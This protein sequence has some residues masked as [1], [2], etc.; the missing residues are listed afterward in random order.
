VTH[1]AKR[2][3]RRPAARILLVEDDEDTRELM[4][5]A[6]RGEGFAVEEATDAAEALKR[7]AASAFDLVITDYDM[8]VQTGAAMLHEAA[9]R[10]LLGSAAALVITA[11]PEHEGVDTME[12][13]RKPIDLGHFLAEIAARLPQAADAATEMAPRLEAVL[14]VSSGSA[15][16]A[17]A[18][19]YLEEL[20]ARMGVPGLR[21][22]VCDVSRDARRAEQDRVVYTPTL[23]RRS[24]GPPVW[25]VGDPSASSVVPDLLSIVDA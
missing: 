18:R 19:R 25:V 12:V 24:P 17:R 14:Y 1:R 9:R 8:P 10:G 6:L 2:D 20:V 21:L 7:L 4:A 16:S 22:D 23:V 13:L 11:H 15:A 3:P 5:M